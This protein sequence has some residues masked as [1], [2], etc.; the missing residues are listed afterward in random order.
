M[1]SAAIYDPGGMSDSFAMLTGDLTREKILL[2]GARSWSREKDPNFKF[3][4][5][6]ETIA[7]INKKFK[8]KYH[9]CEKNSQGD[10]VIHTLKYQYKIPIIGV[11]TSNNLTNADTKRKGKA[12][13]KNKTVAWINILRERGIIQ[14]PETLTKGLSE[15]VDE[16]DNY[17]EKRPGK[18]EA[19]TGHDDYVSCL[20]TMVHFAMKK[21]LRITI[22]DM[23]PVGAGITLDQ[24]LEQDMDKGE[25]IQKLANH[26]MKSR[27]I[28]D[29]NVDSVH[30]G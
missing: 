23:V 20:I 26:V 2:T 6:Y 14:L 7:D 8:F 30:L 10:P 12:V 29:Y 19:L 13:D 15:V 22:K 24:L 17:G 18:Y 16:L 5:V 27:G 9:I 21:F 28:K 11:T 1:P 4:K 3:T 25:R